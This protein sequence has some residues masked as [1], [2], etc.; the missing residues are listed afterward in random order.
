[1]GWIN[2]G[3]QKG[4][5]GARHDRATCRIVSIINFSRRVQA[6]L[7][8]G[9]DVQLGSSTNRSVRKKSYSAT[10]RQFTTSPFPPSVERQLPKTQQQV[11]A[12][13]AR[14]KLKG[15]E[16]FRVAET[17]AQLL[18]KEIKDVQLKKQASDKQYLVAYAM[19]HRLCEWMASLGISLPPSLLS[20]LA[21]QVRRLVHNPRAT[22]A[23]PAVRAQI[24]VPLAQQ[25]SSSK[26]FERDVV[27]DLA[28]PLVTGVTLRCTVRGQGALAERNITESR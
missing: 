20:D 3:R 9:P 17:E 24:N 14:P 4:R 11:A 6:R 7:D 25:S 21:D 16:G 2:R 13:G 15:S 27:P 12:K 10:D 5:A 23:D 28:N 22:R 8:V 18:S 26:S 19:R 1:M